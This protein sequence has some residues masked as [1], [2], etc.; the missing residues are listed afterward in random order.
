MTDMSCS[1][2]FG[3]KGGGGGGAEDFF[4]SMG[5]GG[6]GRAG[7]ECGS[8][9]MG[10]G[11]GGGFPGMGG[12]G[13]MG[14]MPGGSETLEGQHHHLPVKSSSRLLSPSKSCT[15]A[16]RSDSK[17]TVACS[18]VA[19]EEKILEIAYKA[20]WKKVSLACQSA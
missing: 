19:N 2:F 13:G 11:M 9:R 3:G 4:S 20:G 14:G 16:D 5:G 6:G 18:P 17:S 7:L 12:M 10:G 8:S 15:K 1:A